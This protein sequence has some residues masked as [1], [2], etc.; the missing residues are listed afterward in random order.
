MTGWAEALLAQD[1]FGVKLPAA[2]TI[3]LVGLVLAHSTDPNGTVTLTTPEIAA[4]AGL[5]RTVTI[6]AL[7]AL[8]AAGWIE[9]Q[10]QPRSKTPSYSLRQP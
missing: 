9:K 8:A 10:H 5:S 6:R 4:K 1:S 2:S 7:S 3:K